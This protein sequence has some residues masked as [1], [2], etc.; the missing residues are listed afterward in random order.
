MIKK[1][2][3]AKRGEAWNAMINSPGSLLDGY[4]C[5]KV[6][7]DHPAFSDT[8]ENI[9]Y[10]RNWWSTAR[11]GEPKGFAVLKIRGGLK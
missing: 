11:S 1:P 7:A 9:E 2:D 3:S 6:P 4:I 10:W 5:F 8:N